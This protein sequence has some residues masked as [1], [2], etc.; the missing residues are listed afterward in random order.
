MISLEKYEE[1]VNDFLW[2]RHGSR[3]KSMGRKNKL[4]TEHYWKFDHDPAG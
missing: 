3:T 4:N 2:K 1:D